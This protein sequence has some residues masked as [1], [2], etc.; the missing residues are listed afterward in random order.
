M[1]K[2]ILVAF[3]IGA[4]AAV[5]TIGT[6]GAQN[7]P[8]TLPPPP[9]QQQWKQHRISKEWILV[10]ADHKYESC[11]RGGRM[12]G[13]Y[14]SAVREYCDARLADGRVTR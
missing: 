10:P 4:L 3:A 13:Y 2:N 11:L 7:P 14:E 6:A 12:L 8:S 5:S 1:S 9:P